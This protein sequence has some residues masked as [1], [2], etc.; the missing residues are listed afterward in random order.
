MAISFENSLGHDMFPLPPSI[1]LHFG[2]K[3]LI[4][5]CLCPSKTPQEV[6]AQSILSS[7]YNH[8]LRTGAARGMA[9][10][11]TSFST[12]CLATPATW[13]WSAFWSCA[14]W[15]C[16]EWWAVETHQPWQVILYGW[17]T[18]LVNMTPRSLSSPKSLIF[19]H[20]KK[21][22]KH[23]FHWP[24]WVLTPYEPKFQEYLKRVS[25]KRNP[26]PFTF[27]FAGR[28]PSRVAE[29]RD[30]EFAGT[31]WLGHVTLFAENLSNVYPSVYTETRNKKFH[32]M[33]RFFS[34]K[35]VVSYASPTTRLIKHVKNSWNSTGMDVE[36]S[37]SQWHVSEGFKKSQKSAKGQR[38]T[39]SIQVRDGFGISPLCR[40][41][42]TPV[43]QMSYDDPYSV[44]DLVLNS[45]I[46]GK[47]KDNMRRYAHA[48][49]EEFAIAF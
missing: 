21:K 15:S 19:I 48:G 34:V 16:N 25:L 8:W 17:Q 43:L 10:S 32:V 6:G 42:N 46:S 1:Y 18:T 35:R 4:T 45:V 40:W 12:V 11:M 39:E 27:C 36:I 20:Q 49:G 41:E 26:E 31:Q 30:R 3:L 38:E 13:W 29:L 2:F 28:T 37:G 23:V 14:F 33:A 9:T 5:Q 7:Y 44:I 24:A 47:Q 22:K